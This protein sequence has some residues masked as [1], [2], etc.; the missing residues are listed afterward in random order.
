MFDL[1]VK[2]ALD[3]EVGQGIGCQSSTL[4]VNSIARFNA[5]ARLLND[6]IIAMS[7]DDPTPG[8]D[9]NY[10]ILSHSSFTNVA[11]E[12][13]LYLVG[14]T[15][16]SQPTKSSLDLYL[17]NATPS[18]NSTPPYPL[19]PNAFVGANSTIEH[20]SHTPKSN[21]LT[22]IRTFSHGQIATPNNIA[23]HPSGGFYYTND[24]GIYKAGFGHK[25]SPIAL[26]GDVSYCSSTHPTTC[27]KVAGEFAFPNGLLYSSK[28][29]LLYVPSAVKGDVHV[30]TIDA[31]DPTHIELVHTIPIPYPI[32]NIS[33]DSDGDLYLA[34]L[35]KSGQILS[36]F[37]DPLNEEKK[38]ATAGMRVRKVG[39]EGYVY[40]VEKV[41][42]DGAGEL[43]PASTT[44]VHDKKTGRLFLSGVF[45]HFIAVCEPKKG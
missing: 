40:E 5:E 38:V 10:R 3:A 36:K 33:E 12:H 23:A 18:F 16:V 22:H 44:V 14:M 43:L 32:D 35:P 2:E 39:T 30:Y 20:F 9:Y 41:I 25:F 11:Q 42:E 34:V 24:H 17:I 19:L 8:G 37:D 4:M 31:V 7:I 15:G 29:D 27:E 28:H 1:I 21:T 6:R 26:T 13:S 45:S